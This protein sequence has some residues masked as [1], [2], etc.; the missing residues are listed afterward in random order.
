MIG[1][2]SYDLSNR[3]AAGCL[4]KEKDVEKDVANKNEVRVNEFV[5]MMLLLH[6]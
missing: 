6:F 3:V 1:V 5:K 4:L 2:T